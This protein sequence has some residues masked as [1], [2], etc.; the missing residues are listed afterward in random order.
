MH[1]VLCLSASTL[2]TDRGHARLSVLGGVVEMEMSNAEFG[3]GHIVVSARTKTSHSARL[4][5]ARSVEM[6]GIRN[7]E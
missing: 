5:S 2:S 1:P 6:V 7:E 3:H 4:T